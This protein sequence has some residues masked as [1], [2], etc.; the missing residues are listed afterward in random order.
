MYYTSNKRAENEYLKAIKDGKKPEQAQLEK[1]KVK[2]SGA[3][4]LK[5]GAKMK[6]YEAIFT[7]I[8]GFFITISALRFGPIVNITFLLVTIGS[9]FYYS[10]HLFLNEKILFD[11]T[12]AGFST[13]IIYFGNTFANYLRD[14]NEKKQIR[15]AF[16]QYLSPA[17]VEQ[18]ANDPDKLV[19]GGET[20]NDFSL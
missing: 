15:G 10:N 4:F 11:P 8:L 12:F 9:A 20:K 16:S 6:F 13:F 17:L 18:L 2:V 7:I 19:L 14:A 5:A 3:P 1:E